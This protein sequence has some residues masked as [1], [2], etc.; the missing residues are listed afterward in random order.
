MT[1]LKD[2]KHPALVDARKKLVGKRVVMVEYLDSDSASDLMWYKRPII[3]HF[4]DG[5]FITPQQDDEGN[6]GG[7]LYYQK[8]DKFSIIPTIS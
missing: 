5:S 8:D 4:D 3:I 1:T 2:R 6:D 7:S